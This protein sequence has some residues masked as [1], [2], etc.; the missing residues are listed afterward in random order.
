A[1][2]LGLAFAVLDG[3]GALG[4]LLAG[5]V[6]SF[7]LHYAFLLAAGLAVLAAALALPVAFASGAREA[8]PVVEPVGG[9]E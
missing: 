7:D 5:A 4:A 1:T 9:A 2:T 6:G 3:V 8:A